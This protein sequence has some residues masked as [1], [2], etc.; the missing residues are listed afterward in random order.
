ML[1]MDKPSD[2][3]ETDPTK[4]WIDEFFLWFYLFE[5]ILKIIAMGF[6]FN[7]NSYLRDGWNILDFIIVI[8]SFMSKIGSSNSSISGL[9]A[10]RVLRPLRTVST[11]KALRVIIVTLFA[12]IP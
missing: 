3:E 12:A 1:C 7:K 4:I 9:R 2:E 6:L 11:V 10:L 5:C 8:T